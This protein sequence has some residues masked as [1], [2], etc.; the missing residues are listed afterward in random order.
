MADNP[1]VGEKPAPPAETAIKSPPSVHLSTGVK[2]D[3]ARV[4]RMFDT[5]HDFIWR[6][7]RRLGVPHDRVDDATQQVFIVASQKLD[8]I[9]DTQ[10]R[11]FLYG[12]ALRVAS[13][14]RR[15]APFRKEVL[16]DTFEATDT[17]HLPD[18][19][20]ERARARL[21]LDRIL[22]GMPEECRSV[23]TLY[24][25]EEMTLIEIARLLDIP[26]GTAASRLRRARGLFQDEVTKY[27]AAQD[28]GAK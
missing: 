5:H 2:R 10:E 17:A 12:T 11:S 1:D 7:I 21:V 4:R 22:E 6:Q 16:S 3:D 8:Q 25:L 19:Q 24:E 14:I 15:S 13:D 23:F 27:R 26:Q 18:Q 20:L 28:G 9:G